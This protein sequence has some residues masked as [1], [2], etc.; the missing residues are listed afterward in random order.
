MSLFAAMTGSNVESSFPLLGV[1][2]HVRRKRV[3]LL[4][5]LRTVPSVHR[6]QPHPMGAGRSYL[7][8]T[9]KQLL[10]TY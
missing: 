9:Q 5:E 3:H 1:E 7:E 6:F 4:R 10:R 2:V 8:L